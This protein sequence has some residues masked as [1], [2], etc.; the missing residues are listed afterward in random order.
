M[1]IANSS[2]L[3]TLLLAASFLSCGSKSNDEP[4]P[5]PPAGDPATITINPSE[6]EIG[7]DEETITIYCCPIKLR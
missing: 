5:V 3:T 6:M 2:I 7:A 1:K 4:T